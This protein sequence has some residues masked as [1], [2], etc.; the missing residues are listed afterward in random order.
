VNDAEWKVMGLAP[1][2]KPTYVDKFRQL[3]DVKEDGSFR[4]DMKYFAHHYST[5]L[6]FSRRFEELFGQLQRQP[7]SDL[8][9]FHKDI[10]HSGQKV[11]EEVMLKISRALYEQYHIENLCL[12]GGVGLN[13]VANW[14]ILKQT[15]FKRIFIQPG[16]GDDGGAI[17]A[18]FFVYNLLLK[19]NRKFI[20][21]HTHW[22]P[23][24]SNEEI[25]TYLEARGAQYEELPTSELV[26]RTARLLYENKVVGWF[27]GHMEFGPRA[28]GARSILANPVNPEMKA[29]INRK[30]KYREWFRPFAPS[31][32]RE[33][34]SSYFDI[35]MDSPFM[36]LVPDVLPNKRSLI[37]AVTHHDGT[38]RVQTVTREE[39]GIFYDLIKEFKRLSGV[40]IVLNTSFNVRGEPIV[41][42]PQDAYNCFL[43]SGIDCLAMG[44]FLLTVKQA[45]QSYS[46]E[47]IQALEEQRIVQ[48][49]AVGSLSEEA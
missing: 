22:G 32:L 35:D 27:Q 44:N 43:R 47:E 21:R 23:A 28:L 34:V 37:P 41:C 17:G 11:L 42:T 39:N 19:N 7:E 8:T 15:P 4:L 26:R 18:A 3:I 16:P 1:Y 5:S 20:M 10:A 24:F 29:I 31:V 38:G 49:V 45:A 48:S 25:R 2:G 14:K 46:M 12:A 36:L 33:E 13:S 40:P 30:V 6:V 9:E